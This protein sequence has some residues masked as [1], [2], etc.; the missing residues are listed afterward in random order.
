MV[1]GKLTTNT[2]RKQLSSKPLIEGRSLMFPLVSYNILYYITELSI[3]L[4][5]KFFPKDIV[6]SIKS[7]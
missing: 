7:A 1:Q 5:V 4:C 3:E 6:K 2:L